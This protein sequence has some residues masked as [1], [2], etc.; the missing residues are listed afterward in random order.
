MPRRG[1]WL[2]KPAVYTAAAVV[3]GL[4]VYAFFLGTEL[5]KGTFKVDPLAVYFLAKGIFC[6]MSLILTYS[7]LEALRGLRE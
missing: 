3:L 5:A 4:C 1:D 7:V 6:A 2:A